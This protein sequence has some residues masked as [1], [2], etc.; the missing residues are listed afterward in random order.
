MD[1]NYTAYRLVFY[2]FGLV[3]GA[4]MGSFVN[5]C[6]W[7]LPRGESIIR[8]ASHCPRCQ[9]PIRW[10]DNVPLISYW[11]L[12]GRCRSCGTKISFRY[13]LVEAL[14]A[15]LYLFLFY[16][17]G[18]QWRLIPAL[19]LTSALLAVSF[20]DG[21]HYIIPNKI[22]YPG[23][24]AGLVFSFL[25]GHPHYKEALLGFI[26]GWGFFIFLAWVGPYIFKKEA[27]GYGDVKLAAMLGAFLGWQS[28][29][30]A[31]FW[32][33]LF[34]SVVGL[35]QWV[36]FNSKSKAKTLRV[37]L[38]DADPKRK[39]N[40]PQKRA[41]RFRLYLGY[42]QPLR[43]LNKRRKRLQTAP[44]GYIPFGPFLA[45]GALVALFFGQRA[46]AWYINLF[47]PN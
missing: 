44:K 19:L 14:S 32:A 12:K 16:H 10:Y 6:I 20:I 31:I 42:R 30:F 33:A 15:L 7:R 29:L 13:F 47:P 21:E 4:C 9:T 5:V 46:L 26:L 38:D 41:L 36:F 8:P 25:P 28:L 18:P 37:L 11:L 35:A 22:T 23:I 34:G 39:T 40:L 2:L 27:M 17:F 3:L 1:L 45:G 43:L 24:F